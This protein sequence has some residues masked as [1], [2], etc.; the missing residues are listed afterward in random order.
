MKM[1]VGMI[2]VIEG[3]EISSS[4]FFTEGRTHKNDYTDTH[5]DNA[6]N[7]TCNS[8]DLK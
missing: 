4:F 1:N 2:V 3:V 7:W 8:G 5:W 6:V